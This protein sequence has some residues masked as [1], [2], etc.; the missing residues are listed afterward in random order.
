MNT[1]VT[2]FVNTRIFLCKV[3]H[4]SLSDTLLL[5]PDYSKLALLLRGCR[6]S[7]KCGSISQQVLLNQCHVQARP[8][9]SAILSRIL[10]INPSAF[11]QLPK[12]L[13]FMICA[14][15]ILRF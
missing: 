13:T 12:H 4:I 9:S 3:L 6:F 10:D 11:L 1:P 2:A 14:F 7:G 8:F 15:F 5:Y